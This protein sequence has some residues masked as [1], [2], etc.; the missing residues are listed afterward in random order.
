M[1]DWTTDSWRQ[2]LLDA[3]PGQPD[4]EP[5]SV[6]EALGR[7]LS[8]HNPDPQA[9]AQALNQIV[10]D[11]GTPEFGSWMQQAVMG[12]TTAIGAAL[13]G[14]N[15][16]RAARTQSPRSEIVGYDE[17]G[18][19]I[20]ALA[21]ENK[22]TAQ[23][24]M[25]LGVPA[26][27]AYPADI[28][29]VPDPIGAVRAVDMLP[30]AASLLPRFR[31]IEAT[32]AGSWWQK[33]FR[34][35]FDSQ[36]YRGVA[37]VGDAASDSGRSFVSSIARNLPG[38]ELADDSYIRIPSGKGIIEVNDHPGMTNAVEIYAE[39]NYNVDDLSRLV[40]LADA[41]EY[42]IILPPNQVQY[43]LARR[44]GFVEEELGGNLI[45]YP[46]GADDNLAWYSEMYSRLRPDDP[47]ELRAAAGINE[48]DIK[49]QLMTIVAESDLDRL[50]QEHWYE[51]IDAASEDDI[52][53]VINA[54]TDDGLI[55][56]A[57][58]EDFLPLPD[59]S[60]AS[61]T[62][63]FMDVIDNEMVGPSGRTLRED[64]D[65]AS[66]WGRALK[67]AQADAIRRGSPYTI[68]EWARFL[69]V[70]NVRMPDGS[71]LYDEAG[72]LKPAARDA[73]TRTHGQMN[74]L[75][76][77][78]VELTDE[79]IAGIVSSEFGSPVTPREVRWDWANVG[80]ELAGRD[81]FR[82]RG[83]S[84]LFRTPTSQGA[85]N[86]NELSEGFIMNELPY[87]FNA[88][89]E[90]LDFLGFTR[91]DREQLVFWVDGVRESIANYPTYNIEEVINR[92]MADL[93]VM[94][95]RPNISGNTVSEPRLLI[96]I[97][98]M[99]RAMGEVRNVFD[100]VEDLH[101]IYPD[102]PMEQL[103]SVVEMAL[104]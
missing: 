22:D 89:P 41:G 62:P 59:P 38:A 61:G 82:S 45:R 46:I 91:A 56:K 47:T 10:D 48:G 90:A 12:P 17:A 21:W 51:F 53:R 9:N 42:S 8:M 13:G 20:D 100:V 43:D 39:G 23:A 73:I 86:L 81:D 74:S 98:E 75:S 71:S 92:G 52:G 16:F 36:L 67:K 87:L 63:D 85:L 28:L 2:A 97:R 65:R 31:F 6:W 104:L 18:R 26:W 14:K 27:L 64:V 15:P 4:R 34:E 103:Q 50:G 19:P 29:G 70:E 24:L 77:P 84:N 11:M 68:E 32:G 40:D 3:E 76:D 96:A 94:A 49:E 7:F 37:D 44:L 66:E 5:G 80:G 33:A 95:G 78:L 72:H 83:F 60:A 69:D 55:Q 99:G 57:P 101:K 54:M 35:L 102:I 30:F 25:D 88:D 58:G 1:S 79:Q 93:S